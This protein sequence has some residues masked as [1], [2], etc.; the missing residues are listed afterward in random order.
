MKT[1]R[2]ILP[3]LAILCI[4][5]AVLACPM[6]KDSVPNSDAQQAGG[7]PG[8]FNTRVYLILGTFLAVLSLVI[9]GIW[10]AV[11]TTPNQL[12]DPRQN[13]GFPLE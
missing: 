7:L 6:C 12:R 4:N 11:Q 3:L 1:I 9:G 5:A 10:R 8:G 13:R 2:I